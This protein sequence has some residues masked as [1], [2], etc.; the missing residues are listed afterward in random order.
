LA[1]EVHEAI[2]KAG[3]AATPLSAVDF[4]RLLNGDD[5]VDFTLTQPPADP[6][7]NEEDS[8][9]GLSEE[10]DPRDALIAALPT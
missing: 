5:S 3:F 4:S 7:F 10:E 1:P 9:I 6:E 8:L 2:R